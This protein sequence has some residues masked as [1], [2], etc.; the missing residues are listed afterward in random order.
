[1]PRVSKVIP[2][3]GF[4]DEQCKFLCAKFKEFQLHAKE[5]GLPPSFGLKRML[6]MWDEEYIG[7]MEKIVGGLKALVA[8]QQLTLPQLGQ[9]TSPKAKRVRRSQFL[10]LFLFWYNRIH[11]PSSDG[12]GRQSRGRWK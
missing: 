12:F 5:F 4:T 11:R 1:M 9:V 7:T 3:N 2:F 8:A 10:F 6:E